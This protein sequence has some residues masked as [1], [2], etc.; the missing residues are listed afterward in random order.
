MYKLEAGT[1][2]GRKLVLLHGMGTGA[3]AWQPQLKDLGERFHV[4]APFLPGYGPN[5]GPFTIE[6]AA[7]QVPELIVAVGS[8]ASVCG[9]SL[10]ALVALEL[11]RSHPGLVDR[12]VLCG[13]LVSVPREHRASSE[14]MAEMILGL[15][16]DAFRQQALYGLAS[17]VPRPHRQLA[18]TEIASLTARDVADLMTLGFDA[19]EWIGEV[20]APALVLCGALDAVNLPLSEELAQRL[21]NAVFEVLPG[22]GHVANLDAPEAFSEALARFLGA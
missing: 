4:V 1:P 18:L 9:L 13:G 22:A 19:S 17:A 20:K 8:P 11:A 5:P 2:H 7:E 21:P 14:A 16:A 10:G 3:S 15:P 12:L 6:G